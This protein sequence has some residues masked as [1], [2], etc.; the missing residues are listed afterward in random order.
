MS[1]ATNQ[2]RSQS[3]KI[4]MLNDIFRNTGIGG[5]L[6]FTEAVRQLKAEDKNELLMLVCSYDNFT[7]DNDPYGEHDFGSIETRGEKYFWKI[8]Y[9]DLDLL[10]RSENPAD[11]KQTKRVMTVMFASEY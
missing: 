11:P 6:I 7:E 5:K 10:Y 1:H 9:Y 8:D 3:V 2:F 4:A